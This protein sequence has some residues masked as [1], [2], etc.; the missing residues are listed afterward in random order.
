MWMAKPFHSS[1]SV[2]SNFCGHML[3]KVMKFAF[4]IH[5]DDFLTASGWGRDVQF[6][7]EAVNHLWG[8]LRKTLYVFF[9]E[10]SFHFLC[11][12]LNQIFSLYFFYCGMKIS[13]ILWI[14]NLYQICGLQIFSPVCRYFHFV[15]FAMQKLFS[16]PTNILLINSCSTYIGFV[17]HLWILSYQEL[18]ESWLFLLEIV[19]AITVSTLV[20]SALSTS[21]VLPRLLLFSFFLAWLHSF[22]F[23]VPLPSLFHSNRDLLR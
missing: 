18:N 13:Y 7:L 22:F 6:H 9:G 23:S 2:S 15:S 8:A 1:P 11:P 14:S 21:G 16:N 3:L 10:M 5:F 4:I 20:E 19:V 17:W 12:F